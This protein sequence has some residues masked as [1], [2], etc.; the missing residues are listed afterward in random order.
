MC[1]SVRQS[2]FLSLSVC[3]GDRGVGNEIVCVRGELGY[4]VWGKGGGGGG[5]EGCVHV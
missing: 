4:F 1:K 3:V 5:G 2:I